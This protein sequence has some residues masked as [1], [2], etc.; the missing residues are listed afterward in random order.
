MGYSQ[1]ASHRSWLA[2]SHHSFYGFVPFHN[3]L[4]AEITHEQDDFTGKTLMSNRE[5]GRSP[6]LR[7]VSGTISSNIL[8]RMRMLA[9]SGRSRN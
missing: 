3:L 7:Y 8:I 1:L 2:E 9:G 6:C 4:L 5:R